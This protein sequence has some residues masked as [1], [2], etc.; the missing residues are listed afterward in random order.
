MATRTRRTLRVTWAPIFSS[1]NLIVPQVALSS[2]VWASARRRSATIR[3][4]AMEANHRR[5][6]L[7]RIVAALVRSA[8]RSSWHSLMRFSISPRAQ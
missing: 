2:R 6:W 7:A 1:V 8:K 4:Y 5:S 3:T